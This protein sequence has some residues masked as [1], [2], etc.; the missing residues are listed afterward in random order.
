M[1]FP[2]ASV[3]LTVVPLAIASECTQSSA[4]D[5]PFA[6]AGS[7]ACA[8][9]CGNDSACLQACYE[10]AQQGQCNAVGCEDKRAT[11]ECASDEVC[12][13]YTDGSLLCLNGDTGEYVDDV[14]GHGNANSGVYTAPN[15]SVTTNLGDG[16]AAAT[17]TSKAAAA[18]G[19]TQATGFNTPAGLPTATPTGDA[20]PSPN[21]TNG[22]ERRQIDI[23]TIGASGLFA[24]FVWNMLN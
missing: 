3:L 13:R 8:N 24:T 18:T 20:S 22:V 19:D 15:G 5:W 6:P 2:K 11:F 4:I 9:Y 14:G 21:E 17:P 10:T 7:D 12:F 1:F 16:A 23:W